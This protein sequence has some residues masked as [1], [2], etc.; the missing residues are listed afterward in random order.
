MKLE[1]LPNDDKVYTVISYGRVT[2]NRAAPDSPI[3][4]VGLSFKDEIK[5]VKVALTDLAFIPQG[6]CWKN[7]Q[8][9]ISNHPQNPVPR[10][11]KRRRVFLNFDQPKFV[12]AYAKDPKQPAHYYIPNF[13]H[14][15]PKEHRESKFLVVKTT[16]GVELLIPTLTIFSK[17]YGVSSYFKTTFLNNEY[18]EAVQ[19]LSYDVDLDKMENKPAPNQTVIGLHMN[20]YDSESIHVHH[21]KHC[22]YFQAVQKRIRHSLHK[23]RADGAFLEIPFWCKGSM[24]LE[25]LFKPLLVDR[26]DNVLR[27][28]VIDIA[29]ISYPYAYNFFRDRANTTSVSS[30]SKDEERKPGW[31]KKPKK[32]EDPKNNASIDSKKSSSKETERTTLN[33]EPLVILGNS[34]IVEAAIR[35][36]RATSGGK[37]VPTDAP[38]KFSNA[39]ESNQADPNVA[40]SHTN[41]PNLPE[42]DDQLLRASWEILESQQQENKITGLG[43][44]ESTDG[45]AR[46]INGA[47][48]ALTFPPKRDWDYHC[49]EPKAA[50]RLLMAEFLLGKEKTIVLEIEPRQSRGK[51]VTRHRGC[52]VRGN[53]LDISKIDDFLED[54]SANRGN[55]DKIIPDYGWAF[56]TYKHVQADDYL[57]RLLISLSKDES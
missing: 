29:G 40:G 57:Q 7:Q 6:S 12:H 15:I 24:E 54:I 51:S 14:R 28:L 31:K 33:A 9:V 53:D 1:S 52:I 26:N 46:F 49:G 11:Y 55:W 22:P 8:R 43:A 23:N 35:K 17:L 44:Y 37:V 5:F 50:R 41:T 45:A 19:L 25:I 47:Y 21:L 4:D 56:Q 39:K 38:E 16:D 36:E 32:D 20:V 27:A 3:V 13:R 18:K 42:G 2:Y 30:E 48:G 34:S 10:I